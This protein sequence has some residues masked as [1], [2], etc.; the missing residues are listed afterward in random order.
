MADT[1]PRSV[2]ERSL[3]GTLAL[4]VHAMVVAAFLGVL[5]VASAVARALEPEYA[6]CHSDR[7]FLLDQG[8]AALP[9]LL[10]GYIAAMIAAGAFVVH[11]V[12]NRHGLRL[13]PLLAG[14]VGSSVLIALSLTDPVI[15]GR[16]LV[17]GAILW[18]LLVWGGAAILAQRS[19]LAAAVA[20]L[21]LSSPIAFLPLALEVVA[22]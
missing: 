2:G 4:A 11:G 5:G 3:G 17:T 15:T 13:V 6:V 9:S 21:W 20:G 14:I 1:A 18:G 7:C 12:R 16:R 22:R 10:A 19:R 8:A